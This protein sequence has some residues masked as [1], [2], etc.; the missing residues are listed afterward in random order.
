M[1]SKSEVS[2]S[3]PI[4]TGPSQFLVTTL[5]VI[6]GN[7]VKTKSGD[8]ESRT[9]QPRRRVSEGEFQNGRIHRENDLFAIDYVHELDFPSKKEYYEGTLR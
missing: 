1:K 5:R 9:F 8:E 6:R 2:E 3:S 4:R 7:H